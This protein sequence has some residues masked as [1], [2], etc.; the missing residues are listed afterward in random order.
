M[1]WYLVLNLSL[2]LLILAT[3]SLE[4]G[5]LSCLL[6]NKSCSLIETEKEQDDGTTWAVLVAGSN[7]Y[8]NYRHQVNTYI[9]HYEYLYIV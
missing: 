5:R 2:L 3:P 6:N 9:D 1:S 7:E 8:Y 4:G